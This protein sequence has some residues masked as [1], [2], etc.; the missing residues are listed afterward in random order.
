MEVSRCCSTINNELNLM[1][2]FKFLYTYVDN[3]RIIGNF[4]YNKRY[5]LLIKLNNGNFTCRKVP[6]L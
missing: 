5:I 4:F 3:Y 1:P 6:I 2:F